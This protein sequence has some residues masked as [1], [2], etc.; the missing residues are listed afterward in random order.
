MT[1]PA[2][3]LIALAHPDDEL[4][5]SGVLAHLSDRGVRVTLVCATN[6]D[7]GRPHPSV[8]PIADLGATRAEELR[9]S[10]K[11]LGID[12]PV[13]L[14]FHDS[15]RKERFRRDDPQALA[16]VDMLTVEAA[17]R[18]VIAST[19]PQVVVTFE[20]HGGY[21]HPDHV[22]I[23]R[24]ATAAFFSSGS[25]GDD[26]PDRL[27]YAGMLTDVFR[28][29][30]DASRGRGILDGLDSDIFGCAPE[31]IA[32]SFDARPY[33]DTKLSVLTAHRSMFG[34]TDD[35]VHNPPP[36]VA[37]ILSTFRPVMEREVFMLGGTRAPIAQWPLGD[38]FEG[39][40]NI[41]LE[42]P[43]LSAESRRQ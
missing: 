26:A 37:Q 19:K 34:I 2:S 10:C 43:I 23:S 27:F 32:V 36:P 42:R 39:L 40:E 12:E 18:H 8:G 1:R 30:A 6:G 3:L 24:A 5:H 13:L 41:R 28:R 38:F 35:M 9:L 7:A 17:L 11:R 4:F 33:M 20:P 16:N 21:Y 22:A 25:M 31:M 29:F 14:G 15:A